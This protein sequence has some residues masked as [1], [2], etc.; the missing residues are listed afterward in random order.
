MQAQLI[1]EA[2]LKIRLRCRLECFGVPGRA[3]VE[4]AQELH[5][6]GDVV[7]PVEKVDL[8]TEGI[9]VLDQAAECCPVV[10]DMVVQDGI[11][12]E[13]HVFKTGPPG[14]AADLPAAEDALADG[15]RFVDIGIVEKSLREA[16][17][18]EKTIDQIVFLEEGVDPDQ[19]E[20]DAVFQVK[21]EGDDLLPVEVCVLLD[22]LPEAEI[23]VRDLFFYLEGQN[24]AQVF[25]IIPL[26]PV[27]RVSAPGGKGMPLI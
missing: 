18:L 5:D 26:V 4:S 12:V 20:A 15:W 3:S 23:T 19:I 11:G 8:L 21:G 1:I 14:Q 22:D 17:Y 24:I 10:D 9:M 13:E 16:G 27:I 25:H 7:L 2:A 6:S